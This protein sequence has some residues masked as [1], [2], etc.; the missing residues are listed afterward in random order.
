[1]SEPGLRLERYPEESPGAG[2]RVPLR[3]AE[4]LGAAEVLDDAARVA[5]ERVGEGVCLRSPRVRTCATLEA[6]C[7]TVG[8]VR[9]AGGCA[10]G[11]HAIVDGF[12]AEVFDLRME[13]LEAEDREARGADHGLHP[14]PRPFPDLGARRV[15][16]EML[17]VR[18]K[19]LVREE[20]RRFEVKYERESDNGAHLCRRIGHLDSSRG[21]RGYVAP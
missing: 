14:A 16:R 15:A 13:D 2:A 6:C 9:D 5:R 18:R 21:P 12:E 3:A 11:A 1:M 8:T 7:R 19:D 17:V 10:L 4:G 20:P